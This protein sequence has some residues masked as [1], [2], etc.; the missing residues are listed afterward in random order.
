MPA[1][2]RANDKPGPSPCLRKYVFEGLGAWGRYGFRVSGFEGFRFGV[3]KVLCFCGSK[4]LNFVGQLCA[5]H[6]AVC[7]S[8]AD[9][10]CCQTGCLHFLE[11]ETLSATKTERLPWTSSCH[12][13]RC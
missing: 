8:L 6:S 7:D 12:H 2:S 4:M 10:P 5:P 1:N 13:D 9:V 11:H 3:C